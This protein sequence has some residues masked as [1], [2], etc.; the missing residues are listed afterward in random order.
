MSAPNVVRQSIKS[1]RVLRPPLVNWKKNTLTP[2]PS[3]K[4]SFADFREG[5]PAALEQ[6]KEFGLGGGS[7]HDPVMRLFRYATSRLHFAAGHCMGT[8]WVWLFCMM[9]LSHP[10]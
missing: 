6:K 10:S 4:L 9:L 2:E 1:A 8:T 5:I 3:T 7:V